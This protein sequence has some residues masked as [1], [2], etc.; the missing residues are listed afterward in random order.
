MEDWDQLERFRKLAIIKEKLKLKTMKEDQNQKM[1]IFGPTQLG[2]ARPGPTILGQEEVESLI[3]V[4]WRSR[5][6]NQQETKGSV[7]G[8]KDWQGGRGW[9]GYFPVQGVSPTVCPNISIRKEQL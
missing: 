3:P 2:A 6:R 4:G 5:R 7:L 1:R 9:K 8:D